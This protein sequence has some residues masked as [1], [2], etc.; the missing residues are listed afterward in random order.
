MD[1]EGSEWGAIQG[2]PLLLQ[3][4]KNVKIF[5]EFAPI[6]IKE[7]GIEPEEYLKLLIKH[8]FKLYL[9]NEQEKKIEPVTINEVLVI[10]T[11]KNMNLLCLRY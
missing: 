6:A 7:F 4:N 5:T 3:Q 11:E 2:M 1:I 9:I 10:Y 8:G